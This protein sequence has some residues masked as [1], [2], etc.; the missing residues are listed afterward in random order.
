M[1]NEN[2][3]TI[4]RCLSKSAAKRLFR[5]FEELKLK[6]LDR[7]YFNTI[8][9]KNGS[10]VGFCIAFDTWKVCEIDITKKNTIL[11][12]INTHS[13]EVR[14]SKEVILLRDIETYFN[15]DWDRFA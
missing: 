8:Y 6:E 3:F 4:Y 14:D 2:H 11:V 15:K 7:S 9:K 12:T 13:V 10:E 5:K 1:Q